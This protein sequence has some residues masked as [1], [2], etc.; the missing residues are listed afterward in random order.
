MS[1]DAKTNVDSAVSLTLPLA[2]RLRALTRPAWAWRA[3]A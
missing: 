1:D 3:P 2:A